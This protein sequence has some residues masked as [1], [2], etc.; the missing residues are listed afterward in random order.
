MNYLAEYER[1]LASENLTAEERIELESVR[2]NEAE[3]RE[4]TRY[5]K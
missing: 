1:W 3:I 4:G 5:H 2:G